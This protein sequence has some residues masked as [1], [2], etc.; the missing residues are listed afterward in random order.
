MD[1]KGY[2]KPDPTSTIPYTSWKSLKDC[3]TNSS[4]KIFMPLWLQYKALDSKIR[5][6]TGM[7]QGLFQQMQ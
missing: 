4:K 2:L 5:A 7:S 1:D 6:A 3:A